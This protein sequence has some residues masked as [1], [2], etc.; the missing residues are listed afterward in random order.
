MNVIE[1]KEEVGFDYFVNLF[2]NNSDVIVKVSEN[3]YITYE[4]FIKHILA[5]EPLYYSLSRVKRHIERKENQR[6]DWNNLNIT[7]STFVSI[8]NVSLSFDN[9]SVKLMSFNSNLMSVP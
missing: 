2:W 1:L 8:I 5:K 3:Q 6:I 4:S 9:T 7:E